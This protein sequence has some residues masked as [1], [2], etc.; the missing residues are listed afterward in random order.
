MKVNGYSDINSVNNMDLTKNSEVKEK[1]SKNDKSTTSTNSGMTI[2]GSQLNLGNESIEEKKKKAQKI[3]MELMGNA[4][5]RDNDIDREIEQCNERAEIHKKENE[6]YSMLLSDIQDEEENLKEIYNVDSDS[7]EQ[8]DLDLL[9]KERESIRHPDEVKLTPEE[10]AELAKIKN[11][12]LTEYQEKMLKLDEE[13]FE[14]NEKI[15]EN[16]ENIRKEYGTARGIALERLKYHE[17]VDAKKQGDEVIKAANKEVMGTIID[18][19]KKDIDDK[20]EDEKQKAEDKAKEEEII[21]DRIEKSKEQ[22]KE[23]EEKLEKIYEL[24]QDI[25]ELS[26]NNNRNSSNDMK[27]SLD[28]IVAEL[29]LS[30]EDLKGAAV[31]QNV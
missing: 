18:E 28:L 16:K 17:M 23:D 20:Y 29:Q 31:D 14:L 21:E 26:K 30:Q 10:N 9:I 24:K 8:K 25:L 13:K 7:K 15:D 22:S 4:F 2:D 6:E 12:S 3:A 27:K 5:K 1:N 11:K 19:A